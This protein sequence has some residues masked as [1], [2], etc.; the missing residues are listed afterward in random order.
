MPGLFVLE[1][2]CLDRFTKPVLAH[3]WVCSAVVEYYH[4]I[5]GRVWQLLI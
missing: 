3:Y 5:I 4:R 2:D 1:D